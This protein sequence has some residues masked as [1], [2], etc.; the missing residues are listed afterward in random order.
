MSETKLFTYQDVAEHNT[1]KDMFCVVHD[2]VYDC[3]KFLDEHPYV[4]ISQLRCALLRILCSRDQGGL[5]VHML[6]LE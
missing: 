4:L 2:K 3:T 5:S 6:I 1:N